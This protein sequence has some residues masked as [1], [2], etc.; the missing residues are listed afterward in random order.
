MTAVYDM[1]NLILLYFEYSLWLILMKDN[2][3][4]HIENLAPFYLTE[5]KNYPS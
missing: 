4:Q 5:T 2:A 1:Y 3:A